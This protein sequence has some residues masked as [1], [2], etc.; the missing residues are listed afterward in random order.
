ML[1]AHRL[2]S[3]SFFYTWFALW[4][5]QNAL[6]NYTI[7]KLEK[8]CN[9]GYYC[10]TTLWNYTILKL[11]KAPWEH[12]NGFT[13]LWNY[14]ILK[15]F[16]KLCRFFVGFTTL[17]NYTILKHRQQKHQNRKVLLPYEITLF[18]NIS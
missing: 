14:T 7:L 18:S 1:K 10:F 13:T 17:W 12:C 16:V 2:K 9:R 11:K 6:W 3:V 8:L 15:H 4:V 5:S